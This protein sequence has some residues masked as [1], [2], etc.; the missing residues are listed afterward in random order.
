MSILGDLLRNRTFWSWSDLA[1]SSGVSSLAG[2]KISN[3]TALTCAA[4]YSGVTLIAQTLGQLPLLLYRRLERGKERAYDHPLYSLLHDEPNPYMSAYTLKETLQGHLLTWGNG[5]AEIDWDAQ[6]NPIAL[7]PLRPDMM[8]VRW[9]NG[10]VIYAYTVSGYGTVDLPASRVFHIPGFGFDGLIGY[11]PITLAREAIG[12]AKG[13]EEFGARFFNS[14]TTLSGVLKHPGELSPTARENMRKSWEEAYSGLSSQHRVAILEEGVSFEKI[15]IP[16]EN[17]QFLETRKFQVAEIA[18]FLHVPPHMI[19]DLERATYSNIEHQGIEF[20][21]YTMA[22][23]FVRWEQTIN[24][25]LLSRADRQ[26]HFSEFLATGLLRGDTDARYKAY[27]IGKQWGWLS[28]NDIREK[29]NEN[30]IPGGDDYWMP[31]NMLPIGSEVLSPTKSAI[32]QLQRKAD[33]ARGRAGLTRFRIAQSYRDAF[34]RAGQEIVDRE[35]EQVSKGLNQLSKQKSLS[36]KSILD[37]NQWLD[38]F[39]EVFKRSVK[40]EIKPV[41]NELAVAIQTVAESE[42]NQAETEGMENFVDQYSETFSQRYIDSSSGQLKAITKEA[43]NNDVNPSPAIE[44]R[45][46]EWKEKR[47][48]KVGMN[49]TVQLSNAV[50]K[51][52][53]GGAGITHLIWSAQGSESC[54]FCRQMDGR[55]VGIR[56][57]FI[58]ANSELV[59][60]DGTMKIY[61]PKSHPPIHEGCSCQIIPG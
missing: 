1:L 22:P 38:S 34:S 9:E 12:L 24:R 17:A 50:A 27:S 40:D 41:A 2:V 30:P 42:V 19:G 51:F 16:P 23:W 61:G 55:V 49:E 10:K 3:S 43:E 13:T 8:R 25:K 57:D 11:D 4:Y 33:D 46:S 45:L 39:Y 21:V 35:V 28:S 26:D 36:Q 47:P 14:G 44:T 58:P 52:V 15:G 18:R 53:C 56:E 60:P 5:F 32:H 29:E 59:S 54:P 6:G 7:W 20:I 48:S 37:W 31:L